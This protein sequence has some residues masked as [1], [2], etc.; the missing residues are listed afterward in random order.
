VARDITKLTQV[1]KEIETYY[2]IPCR[3]LEADLS[4][5]DCASRIYAATSEAGLK[6]DILIN[7]A[8][9][10]T[11]GEMIE[12]DIDSTMNMLQVNVGS[13]VQLSHLYGKDMKDRRVRR[14]AAFVVTP[15]LDALTALAVFFQR[16]RMLFVSSMVGA[17]PSCPTVAVYAGEYSF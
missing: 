15:L 5:P 9:V 14:F 7:N 6:V 4:S 11:Q 13:V 12:G 16:G 3:V 10:C 1:A 2:N 17:L 8:G